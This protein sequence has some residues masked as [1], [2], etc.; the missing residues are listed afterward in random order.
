MPSRPFT[1]MFL[2]H[3]YS[4]WPADAQTCNGVKNRVTSFVAFALMGMG[5]AQT[6]NVK[7]AWISGKMVHAETQQP[8]PG[9]WLRPLGAGQGYFPDDQGQFSFRMPGSS[10]GIVYGAP[11]FYT[12]TLRM[13]S[14]VTEPILVSLRPLAI[15]VKELEISAVRASDKMPIAQTTL[16]KEDIAKV[17]LGKDLPMLLDQMPSVV[18]NSDAGAGVGYTGM[19]IRGTDPTRTNVTINGIPINDAES[20][21]VFWVNMPDLASSIAT[22]QIQRGIGTSSHGAGAFGATVNIQ[23]NALRS[24]PFAAVT[25]TAGS[26][27]TFRNSVEAGTGLLPGGFTMDVRLSKITSDG[28]ID[29]SWSDLK[30]F[31][32]SGGWYGKKTSVRFNVFSGNEA[33]YQA[34]YGVPAFLK[35]SLPRFNSAGTDGGQKAIPYQNET[36][37]YQQD[38]YQFFVNHEA[39]K[40]VFIQGAAYYTRGRGFYE[41][42]KV[43]AGLDR[44]GI[45]PL[46]TGGGDTVSQ[47]DLIR[48]LWLDNHLLGGMLTVE[49]RKQKWQFIGGGA[50]NHYIGDHFGRVIWAEVNPGNDPWRKYYD[51]R[52]TKTDGN[53]YGRLT[54]DLA[55]GLTAFVDLQYRHVRYTIN[56]FRDN[57]NLSVDENFHFFNPKGGFT[58]T[59]P[60]GHRWYLYYGMASKEPNRVD[61]ETPAAEIPK[62][63]TLRDLELGYE[64]QKNRWRLGVNG[65]WMDYTNQ[66]ILTG[67]IND[68]GAYVRTNAPRSYRLGMEMEG[69]WKPLKWM[70]VAGNL[71]VSTNRII[72]FTEF[73]DDYDLG[74]Q[75]TIFRGNTPIAFSPDYVA[76]LTLAFLPVQGL[77]L[78]LVQKWVGAQFLDNSGV[79]ERTLPAFYVPD[80]RVRYAMAVGKK[81]TLTLHCTG[82]NLTNQV[83]FPNGYSFSYVW[84]GA[85]QTENFVYPMAGFHLLGGLQWTFGQP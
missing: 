27:N 22:L 1:A 57:P 70:E 60:K 83:Y 76:G 44:Y 9:A 78:A 79:A 35:D 56:G 45:A 10:Q 64:I 17:N 18:V 74:G 31:F 58:Y 2:Y 73:V 19:R 85:M 54:V 47:S 71:N 32:M 49:V 81:S 82:Y 52:G 12:D 24:Q 38:H 21:G 8:V 41:Q 37:N 63:E 62:H 50:L 7:P 23:T 53:V 65:Y 28:F 40:D 25:S 13:R 5:W 69:A 68:V 3:Q 39:G 80:L 4:P 61:Y 84:N 30:S 55:K 33:T 14:A 11:G 16:H 42:Y 66:L 43:Q 29:R 46:V 59:H 51:N 6:Q 20:Q 36:D 72:D 26:F 15:L 77:E 67:K 75:Q 34:W 48:Q